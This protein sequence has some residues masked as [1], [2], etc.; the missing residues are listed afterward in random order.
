MAEESFNEDFL[1]DLNDLGDSDDAEDEEETTKEG[2]QQHQ[3]KQQ[4]QSHHEEPAEEGPNETPEKV[5]PKTVHDVANLRSQQR[6][7][8][9]MKRVDEALEVE[10]PEEIHGPLS[11]SEDYSLVIHSNKFINEIDDHL[12]AAHKFVADLYHKKFPELEQLV[13]NMLDYVNVVEKIQ[14]ET[15]LT[16]VDL[17]SVLPATQVMVVTVTASTTNGQP[18]D[19]EEMKKCLEGCHEIK[20]LAK[21]KERI[22][23]F[24]ESRMNVIAPNVSVLLSTEVAAELVG[25]V[26]GVESLSKVPAC[27]VQVIGQRKKVLSG[28]SRASTSQHE[29][30]VFKS[31]LVQSAPNNLRTKAA[32]VLAGKVVLAARIDNCRESK[33]GTTGRHFYEEIEKKIQ[34]WQE[35]PPGKKKKPLPRPD[36]KPSRKRGGKRHRAMKEKLGMTDVRKESSRMN[37]AQADGEYGDTVMGESLGRLSQSGHGRMRVERKEQKITKKRKVA[38]NA[39]GSSG[40]T[41]GLA[42]SLVFTPHQGMELVNPQAAQERVKKANEKYFNDSGTFSKIQK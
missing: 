8:E 12:Q 37:F 17:Q 5:I 25:V 34:K 41:S 24:I 35:P 7:Q 42:S 14:N 20:A 40:A 32:K 4:Q 10:N 39:G 36:D 3:E 38:S 19:A 31:P 2:D 9:M 27:N 6:F 33:D 30:I 15:D 29:G 18:L 26:G 1:N 13:P 23:K 21:A 22:L 16:L 11:Q 28:F